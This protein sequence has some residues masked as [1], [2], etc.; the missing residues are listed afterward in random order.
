MNTI[1][2]VAIVYLLIGIFIGHASTV[3]FYDKYGRKLPAHY[4][5]LGELVVFLILMAFW[6]PILLWSTVRHSR[7]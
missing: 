4:A 7:G 2:V 3:D 5:V 1:V 6:L